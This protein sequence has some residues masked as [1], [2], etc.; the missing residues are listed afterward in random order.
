M[1]VIILVVKKQNIT[2]D[3]E[4]FEEFCTFAGKKGIK[5]STWINQ[6]MIEFIEEEEEAKKAK[7]SRSIHE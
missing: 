7:M 5:I 1:G 6:K 2:L 3:P 4:V